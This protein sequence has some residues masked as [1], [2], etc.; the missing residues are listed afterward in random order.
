M[1]PANLAGLA[2][3]ILRSCVALQLILASPFIAPIPSNLRTVIISLVALALTVGAFTPA[4]CLG[5]VLLQFSTV[6]DQ[7]RHAGWSYL[8][9]LA[10]PVVVLLLGPGAYS[11]DAKRY[12]RRVISG[13]KR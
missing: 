8:V 7:S 3:V 11:L 2:L 5:S 6:Q 1:F 12:G 13:P 4:A 9:L 10:L